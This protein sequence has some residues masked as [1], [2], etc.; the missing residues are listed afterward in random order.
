[1]FVVL[2]FG[3]HETPDHTS[4]IGTIAECIE[5]MCWVFPRINPHI[6]EWELISMNEY[7]RRE[8]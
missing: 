4:A 2:L 8:Y 7:N 3:D 6:T 5:F 1:M